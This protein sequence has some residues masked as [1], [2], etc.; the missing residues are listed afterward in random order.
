MSDDDRPEDLPVPADEEADELLLQ[1][2]RRI[3]AVVDAPP[4]HVEELA[5]AAL[6]T[7]HLDELAQLLFDSADAQAG[8]LVRGPDDETRV[9]TYT[10]DGVGIDLELT[11][12]GE[13]VRL[14]GYV[15]AGADEVVVEM[16]RSVVTAQL[17]ADGWFDATGLQ[18]GLLR[19]RVTVGERVV[20]TPWIDA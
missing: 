8:E 18:P 13:E 15:S 1:Q 4:A 3:A 16:A 20:R 17:D 2:L 5:R 7:R 14:R 6:A 12:T 9:L 11:V 10:A 19:V